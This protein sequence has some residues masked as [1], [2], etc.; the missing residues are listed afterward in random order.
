MSGESDMTSFTSSLAFAIIG[1]L[2]VNTGLNGKCVTK[3]SCYSR[4]HA[5][6]NKSSSAGTI[7]GEEVRGLLAKRRTGNKPLHVMN[8]K[9]KWRKSVKMKRRVRIIASWDWK[10]CVCSLRQIDSGPPASAGFMLSSLNGEYLVFLSFL[11]FSSRACRLLGFCAWISRNETM[12]EGKERETNITEKKGCVYICINWTE[13][14]SPLWPL[15]KMQRKKFLIKKTNKNE[16]QFN[17]VINLTF[18]LN[19]HFIY[20]TVFFLML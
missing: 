5:T 10:C 6:T 20:I 19:W 14:G 4:L 15:I 18:K 17:Y 2:I 16:L 3:C 13:Y 7:I 8:C 11:C 1:L 12:Q 9:N